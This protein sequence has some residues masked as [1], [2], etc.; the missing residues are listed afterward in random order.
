MDTKYI[1]EVSL[2]F[3][4]YYSRSQWKRNNLSIVVSYTIFKMTGLKLMYKIVIHDRKKK[5]KGFERLDW[6]SMNQGESNLNSKTSSFQPR[7]TLL[8]SIIFDLTVG[9]G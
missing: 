2:R 8:L 4:I 9:S 7:E 3:A 1:D 5:E 6:T